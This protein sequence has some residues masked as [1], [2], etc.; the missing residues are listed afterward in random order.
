MV[1]IIASGL[2]GE[3]AAEWRRERK[4]GANKRRP[5]SRERVIKQK[6]KAQ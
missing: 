6:A 1:V 4:S 2:G 5:T 3:R